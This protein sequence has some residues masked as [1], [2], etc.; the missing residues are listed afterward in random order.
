MK[1]LLAG[2]LLLCVGQPL[3]AKDAEPDAGPSVVTQPAFEIDI[4]APDEV[5]ELLGKNLEL[6][7][8]RELADLSDSELDQLVAGARQNTRDLLAT[9]GY[10]SPDIGI[11][12][13]PAASSAAA[14]VVQLK[15]AP[16]EPTRVA[17]V[18]IEFSGPIA[19]D[20]AAA[21][22]RQI[23]EANWSLRAGARFTQANWDSA[24]RQ[25]LRQLTTLRY[26]GGRL[27]PTLADV[28]LESHSARL[29][30]MLESGPAYKI[31]GLV[32][33]GTQHHD[34]MLVTRLAHLPAGMDYAQTELSQAQQRLT[35][36][37]YF[38]SV[39]VTLDVAGDPAAA[40]VR[41]QVKEARLQKLVLGIGASTD[42]G[43]R[44][45][46]EHT[47]NQVPGIGWRAISK[48][49][50]DRE[51]PSLGTE[52]TAPPDEDNWRWVTGVQFQKE[53]MGSFDVP[54]ERLR[55]GRS[56][57]NVRSE[58]NYYLQYDRS[59]NAATATTAAGLAD[60]MSANYAWTWRRFDDLVFPSGGW[61][62]AVEVGGGMTLDAQHNPF[63]RF[64]GRWLSYLPL[65]HRDT[66]PQAR[67]G[68]L[69]LRAEAGAVLASDS[70]TL[71]STQLFVTGGATSVR[72]Y[73]YESIGVT[74]PD[75]Q[76]T[77]GRYMGLGSLEWQ[78]PI[79]V[80]DQLTD[81]ESTVFVDAGAVA[82]KPADLRAQV[83]VGF[84][85]RW[86]SPVGPLQ[87]DLGYGVEV[88]QF[89]L[90]MNLGFVF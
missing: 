12:T 35:E 85:A 2:A 16:G 21:Q 9:L 17:E 30:V 40:P 41:V 65:S 24:K 25:A 32:V 45:T 89:R 39:S 90:H 49:S 7:R 47:H 10:F 11:E 71:P 50:M 53:P 70:A 4:Q 60:S 51:Q 84:G 76:T 69:A 22:Q 13:R 6:L 1:W 28:D 73:A 62:L 52:L 29:S 80:G 15:V 63:G 78:R 18:K 19:T 38:D 34:P 72:G 74:L 75:G 48:L 57:N 20:A 3:L 43:F 66:D 81:W 46:A 79:V 83:G 61:G 14:R 55:L 54:S 86:K 31:G 58:R 23:I 82:D 5:K 56:Q 64:V 77:V 27:G 26:A 33:S 88:R 68:R 37:G 36:S 59:N 44:L 8:Y 42:T 87:L 67:A